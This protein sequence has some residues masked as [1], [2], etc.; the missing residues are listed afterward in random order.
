VTLKVNYSDRSCK[1]TNIPLVITRHFVY[2]LNPFFHLYIHFYF[3][4]TVNASFYI[5]IISFF[6]YSSIYQFIHSRPSMSQSMPLSTFLLFILL[7]I[8]QFIISSSSL[9]PHSSV[10]PRRLLR[11]HGEH[12]TLLQGRRAPP[13][14][15]T[16]RRSSPS[17]SR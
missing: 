8:P 17:S 11:V 7:R 2:F 10:P 1:N 15:R 13:S 12:V 16:W 6:P 5:S 4:F 14:T 9:F 3:V